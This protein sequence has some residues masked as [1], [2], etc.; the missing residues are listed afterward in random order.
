[1]TRSPTCT[2]KVVRSF[3]VDTRTHTTHF[4]KR[5]GAT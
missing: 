1:V 3:P 4:A 5:K 2:V